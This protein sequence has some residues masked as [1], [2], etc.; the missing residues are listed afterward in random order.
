MTS[1][2]AEDHYEVG[3]SSATGIVV[4]KPRPVATPCCTYRVCAWSSYEFVMASAAS[5]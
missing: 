2:Y 3:L 1:M 4:R 5:Y